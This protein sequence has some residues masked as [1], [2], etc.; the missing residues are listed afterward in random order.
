[1]AIGD[2]FAISSV[3]AITHVSGATNYTVL[4]LH[5][6]LQD[7]ADDEQASVGDLI[8]ITTTTPSERSTD[9]IITL[10][11]PFNINDAAAQFL[12]DGSITQDG[13]DTV[14]AG[15]VCV[16]AVEAGTELQITQDEVNLTSH[17]STGKNIDAAANILNRVIVKVR[18]NGADLDGRKLRVW[19]REFSDSYSEFS[20]TCALGNNVA[21][22]FTGPDLNNTTA[23]GTVATWTEITNTEGYQLYDISGN[24]VN[25]PYYS[26]WD[27]GIR[28]A[29]NVYERTKYIQRRTSSEVIHGIDGELFRGITHQINYN[30]ESNAFTEDDTVAWGTSFDYNTG[31]GTVPAVGQYWRNTT[32]GGV[33]KIV[34]V[35]PGAGATGTVVIQRETTTA[36]WATTNDFTLLGG[37]GAFKINGA[38]TGNTNTG[39]SGLL[40]ALL[41][42]GATG[43]LWMQ[44][45]S[46][47]IG[48]TGYELWQ[49]G[50]A[51]IR[52]L[53]N[54]AATAR[55]ISPEFI[56]TYTGTAFIGAFGIGVEPTDTK[57]ADL[58]TDLTNSAWNPPN[59]Q[60]F[61]VFGLV[62]GD[63]V[64]V[65]NND[66]SNIDFN[67][68]TL[69][70]A[71]TTGAVTSVV[72][73]GAIPADTPAT[74]VIRIQLDT[75]VY[76][77][78]PYTSWASSTFTIGST[79]FTDPLDAANGNN[80][81]IGYIDL[82]TVTT[83]EAYTAVYSGDR[84][85][86]VR[87]RDG[88]VTPIKTFESTAAFG[89]GG[90]SATAI[91]T[92]DA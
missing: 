34:Y 43:T 21:A 90:G 2:D 85:L 18:A 14:Y 83:S 24:A 76:R 91:R 41:D 44:L 62:S 69:N 50:D 88:G 16:G 61:T 8:D 20:L 81:F 52:A 37:T 9:N 6:W 87:V 32:V 40:L 47:S 28:T 48:A 29:A 55:T 23:S 3:G 17:W 58:F 31:T 64:M 82:A 42:S 54:G 79:S 59:T 45:I 67:Q 63:R 53:Q 65:A 68:F 66:T 74:G 57:A 84:T 78:V 72:V 19:A 70:G 80:V 12:Y 46:G 39:G 38:V 30:T 33:G 92:S 77:R 49:R 51:S 7:L 71:L 1:M 22:I 5:R 56:G 73:N 35:S 26:R 86:F 4:E 36:T 15:L 27:Y 10:N 25:E 60:T 13:G 75:G 11:S 89:S